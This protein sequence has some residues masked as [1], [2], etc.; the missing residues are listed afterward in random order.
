MTEPQ[1]WTLIAVFTTLVFGML[2]VVSTMF[3]RVV[4]AEI[5][6]L[7]TK[8]DALSE[9]VDTRLDNLDRDVQALV[10]HTFGIDRG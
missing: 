3:V 8:I 6:R 5:G 2:T 9:K 7:D 10:R 4:R 1:V